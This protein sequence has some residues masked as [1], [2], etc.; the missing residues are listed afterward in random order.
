MFPFF[1]TFPSSTCFYLAF[2]QDRK[3]V[4]AAWNSCAMCSKDTILEDWPKEFQEFRYGISDLKDVAHPVN[5]PKS[6]RT[7]KDKRLANWPWGQA[8]DT[9][10]HF[11]YTSFY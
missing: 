9:N 10:R 8:A 6:I 2:Y 1:F 7:L 11:E 5:Y 3:A 4:E